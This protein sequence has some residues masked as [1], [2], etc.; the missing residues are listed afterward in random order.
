MSLKNE[1][2]L[3]ILNKELA[4]LSPK[5]I[6]Q[7]VFNLDKKT[8]ITTNFRPY[9]VAILHLTSQEK[10]D[11]K[12]VWCDTGYNTPQTYKHAEELIERLALNVDLYVPKQTVAHR[13]VTMG[14]PSVDDK[15]HVK[16]TEQVKLEPFKRA[17][18]I[19]QPEIWF[20]NLRKGQTAFRDGI[21]V[22]SFSKDGI[23]KVSPFYHWTDEDLDGYLKTHKLPNEF[24]Y[25]DP[26]KVESNREC[27]LHI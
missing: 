14:L 16:F 4:K 18:K 22:L 2:N 25:F 9:E 10:S 1:L 21:G 11:I 13:T 17:M 26:T 20:T 7:W 6:V 24:K 23:L 12:V 15:N 27:G 19:H 5:E 3:E 8:I